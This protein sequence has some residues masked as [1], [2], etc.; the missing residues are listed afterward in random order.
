ML[1]VKEMGRLWDNAWHFSGCF[2]GSEKTLV[3]YFLRVI[4]S[5]QF[6]PSFYAYKEKEL[7]FD[8]DH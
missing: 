4:V 6:K 8:H 5:G 2:G 3:F 1:S 7:S